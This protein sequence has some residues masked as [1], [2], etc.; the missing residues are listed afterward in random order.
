[1]NDKSRFTVKTLGC[2]YVLYLSITGLYKIIF[3]DPQTSLLIIILL[4]LLG[5][6]AIFLFIITYRMYENSKKEAHKA[7]QDS[8][9][10]E[11]CT[12]SDEETKKTESSINNPTDKNLK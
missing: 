12:D 10:E 7:Q 4:S 9:S 8:I 3:H 2:A 6:L 5:I 1:M 11:G